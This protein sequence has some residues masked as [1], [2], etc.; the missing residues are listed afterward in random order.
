MSDTLTPPGT[1]P[2]PSPDSAPHRLVIVGGGF[3]GLGLAKSLQ[4]KGLEITIID[5]RNHHLFQPLLYQVATTILPTSDVAWPIRNLFKSRKDVTTLLDEVT[6]VDT[7]A[8]RVLLKEGAPVGYDTLVLATGARHSYFGHD[9]WEPFAPGLKSLEDATT[10]R[11]RVLSAFEEAE[12]TSD[13]DERDALLSF[14]IV[15]AGATG[16]ELA[17]IIAELAQRILPPEFRNI[18]TRKARVILIEAG[19]RVLPAFPKELSDYAETALKR[20]GVTVMT[21]HA[22]TAMSDAGVT[23]SG[24]E[25]PTRTA[26]WAA[27]VTAS[28]AAGWLG[29]EADRAG[30]VKVN[31]DLTVP[32]HPDIFVIGDTAAVEREDGSPVPGLAPAAKQQGQF[33][34]KVL[35]ARLAGQK[36]DDKFVYRHQ[37]SLATIGKRSAVADFGRIRLKGALA[38]WLWGIAHIYFLIGTRSR[39][40]VALNWLWSFISGRNSARLITQ[41]DIHSDKR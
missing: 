13:A 6:G 12:L 41:R 4:A 22:V 37:G 31:P 40:A 10:I 24:Q 23:V 29:A 3:G 26:I 33:V 32:G 11:R 30:R 35:K 1:A 21:D 27:G 8:K 15:G 16:V 38:W 2:N 14:V 39:I 5:Q 17:G 34:A 18:D 19:P 7:E 28:P 25:I 9:E 36:Q 20:L